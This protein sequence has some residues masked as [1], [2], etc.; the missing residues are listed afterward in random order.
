[1]G[2]PLG[3]A[4]NWNRCVELAS[5]EWITILHQ[6]DLLLP[7]FIEKHRSV[8]G[9]SVE[10]GR[11]TC[12]ADLVDADG[13]TISALENR[14]DM[15]WPDTDYIIWQWH[16]MADVLVKCNPLRCPATSFRRDLHQKIGGFD[17]KWKY[18]VDWDFWY[19]LSQVANV[20]MLNE[21]LAFQRWHEA[22]ETQRL[23]QGTIDLEENE[24]IM[25]RILD[26]N[27]YRKDD[28]VVNER[29]ILRRLALAWLARATQAAAAG[30]RR[31]ELKLLR[32]AFQCDSSMT[33]KALADSPKTLAM[34]MLGISWRRRFH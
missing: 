29:A 30:N 27:F 15:K 9:E 18:V 3:L 10:I 33:M 4:G 22:S 20:A 14:D 23:A 28:R 21:K 5:G 32:K 31:L 6:D 19:R 24:A 17:V 25:Y 12:P 7:G 2:P 8:A 16:E 13:N 26:D 11:I 34:L 1:S